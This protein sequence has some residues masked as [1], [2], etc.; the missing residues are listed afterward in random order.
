[1]TILGTTGVRSHALYCFTSRSRI[2]HLFRDVTIYGE[3]LHNLG[4]C[5]ALRAFQQGGIF[6]MPHLWH[7][8]SFFPVSSEEPPYSVAYYGTQRDAEDLLLPGSSRVQC[9]DHSYVTG[10]SG[11][12][13]VYCRWTPPRPTHL[14]VSGS[15]AQSLM[16]LSPVRTISMR[17]EESIP[18]GG[19]RY[20]HYN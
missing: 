14:A 11:V 2:F 19:R 8:A 13:Y 1:M 15:L 5:S 6:I 4:L 18:F 10:H 12:S 7:G 3:G 16:A 17:A 20:W 9:G